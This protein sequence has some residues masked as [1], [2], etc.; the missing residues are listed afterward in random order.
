MQ[1]GAAELD[2]VDCI[3]SDTNVRATP[4]N[5]DFIFFVTLPNEKYIILSLLIRGH[6]PLMLTRLGVHEF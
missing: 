6:T 2:P 4:S 5:S 3:G 1:K